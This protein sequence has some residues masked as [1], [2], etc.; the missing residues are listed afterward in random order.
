MTRLR[1]IVR[2]RSRHGQVRVYFWRGKGHG[3]VRLIETEGSAAF[4]AR[5]AELLALTEIKPIAP[6]QRAASAAPPGSLGDLVRRYQASAAFTGYDS[7]TV[8]KRRHLLGAMM[9]EPIAPGADALFRDFPIARLTP[10]AL[11]VLRDRAAEGRYDRP[12]Q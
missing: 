3:K 10:E 5:Y 9:A 11:A 6:A 1:Y 8:R 4:H 7:A 2:D 12:G